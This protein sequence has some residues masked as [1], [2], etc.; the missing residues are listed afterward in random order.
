METLSIAASIERVKAVLRR[1]PDIGLKDDASATTRWQ[2]GTRVVASHAN[3]TRI[4]TDMPVELGGTGDQVTP[5]WLMRAGLASCV[6]TRVAMAA[7]TEGIE[8]DLLEIV[9]S[10]RSNACGLFDLPDATGAPVG[11]GPLGIELMVRIAAAGV[12][13]ER[14]RA[15]VEDSN[16]TAPVSNAICNA[17][18][19]ALTVDVVGH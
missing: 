18:P 13:P 8:L 15:L 11:A 16:R 1:R 5:G 14:L 3:G 6:V 9:A 12:A 4:E 2:G 17:T 7:A 10:S 19:L